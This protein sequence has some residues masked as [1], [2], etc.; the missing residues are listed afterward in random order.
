MMKGALLERK[1]DL[2]GA[3]EQYER[4]LLGNSRNAQ[5]A[6]NLACLY[7]LDPKKRDRAFE[8]AKQ[9]RELMPK[10]PSIA[11]T[12][13]WILYRR[14]DYKWALA[15][16]Q[17]SA[18]LVAE[19][20]EVQYHLGMCQCAVGNEDAAREALA[21][22]LKSNLEYRGSDEAKDVAALLALSPDTSDPSA[23]GKIEAF[24]AQYPEN[25]A[26]WLRLGAV[27][28][29][30][31]DF[32]AA[33]K[34][35]ERALALNSDYVPGL[36]R[37]AGLYSSHLGDLEKALALA[38]QARESAP[39][40]PRVADALA[41]IAFRRGDHKWA[42]GLLAESVRIL[43]EDPTIQ[44]HFGMA[45]F[46]LGKIDL[47]TNFIRKALSSPVGFQDAK[48][49]EKLLEALDK[50]AVGEENAG[51][52]GAA[53]VLSPIMLPVM[54]SAASTALEK[55]DPVGAQRRYERVV[56]VYPEFIPAVRELALLYGAQK[57]PTEQ[58]FKIGAKARELLPQD[59]AVAEALGKI[60]FRRGQY[61]YASSLLQ[62][63]AD[64]LTANADVYYYLGMCHHQLR[65]KDLAK[66]ALRRALE[67]EPKAEWAAS[68]Q[69]V[70]SESK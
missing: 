15:L 41:W 47:A 2:A 70:L 40:N 33:Q 62:E 54:L 35:Y 1:Q 49:A 18:D 30:G 44:Y 59:P 12:L 45:N 38:K 61:T 22:A 14:G 17:E 46:A 16:L 53:G 6:N 13:G 4:I 57:M 37:L 50:P 68:A 11:D 36:L 65:K 25:P 56:S 43:P 42:H 69:G 51:G 28:E 7:S 26:A 55:G 39:G 23:R 66:K 29:G 10:D 60:A 9:A 24:L 48:D 34:A 5:A 3:A 58:S 31:G 63:S 67:L 8:L 32:A 52:E 21:A 20:P 19:Q 64:K 27:H